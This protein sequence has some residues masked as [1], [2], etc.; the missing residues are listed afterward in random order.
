MIVSTVSQMILYNIWHLSL[1][2]S[3]RFYCS[4]LPTFQAIKMLIKMYTKLINGFYPNFDKVIIY[5]NVIFNINTFFLFYFL[6]FG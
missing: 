3:T 4:Y 2:I 1:A 6:Q 5:R